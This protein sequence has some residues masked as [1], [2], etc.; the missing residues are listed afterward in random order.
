[1]TLMKI[2]LLEHELIFLEGYL[3]D[4]GISE[5]MFKHTI[6]IAKKNKVKIA[7][8]LSDIFCVTQTQARLL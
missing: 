1:M 8:S 7:M 2:I 3:W 4:K 6:N 5:K